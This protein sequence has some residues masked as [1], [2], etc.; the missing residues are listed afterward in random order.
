MD[1]KFAQGSSGT[2]TSKNPSTGTQQIREKRTNQV[3]AS[4]TKTNTKTKQKSTPDQSTFPK[5]GCGHTYK[6]VSSWRKHWEKS[7]NPCASKLVTCRCG[8]MNLSPENYDAS[9]NAFN[10]HSA[11]CSKGLNLVN[12]Q[13]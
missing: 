4:K 8:K 3:V 11:T 13:P 6:A 2:Q 12:P 10:E 9:V 5:C 1:K 7:K